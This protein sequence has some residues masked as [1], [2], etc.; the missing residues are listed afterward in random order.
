[1]QD[2]VGH[3]GLGVYSKSKGKSGHS[4]EGDGFGASGLGVRPEQ[5]T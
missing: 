2:L 4:R 5:V 1:M 3:R